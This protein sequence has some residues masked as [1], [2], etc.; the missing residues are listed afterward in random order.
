MSLPLNILHCALL[1][2]FL[3]CC[4]P[5]AD[6]E[7]AVAIGFACDTATGQ[8][9]IQAMSAFVQARAFHTKGAACNKWLLRP[10]CVL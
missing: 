10:G 4:T 3:S 1:A 5:H 8:E 6:A 2:V 9:V 7:P